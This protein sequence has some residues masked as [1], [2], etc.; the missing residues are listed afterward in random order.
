MTFTPDGRHLVTASSDGFRLWPA[1]P[2]RR[3]EAGLRHA[4]VATAVAL[5]PDGRLAAGDQAGFDYLATVNAAAVGRPD[6]VALL[7]SPLSQGEP[8]RHL[9]FSRDGRK[10]LSGGDKVV[11]QW[12]AATGEPD[13]PPLAHG[14]K[15][16]IDVVAFD[17]DGAGAWTS[18]EETGG[19]A[20]L[21]HWSLADGEARGTSVAF[22]GP[23]AAPR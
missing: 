23:G 6:C 7:E 17:R 14:A 20:M 1:A 5:G 4:S 8:V 22:E 12:S 21:R 13:G 19:R 2:P 16:H 3:P 9:L 10:L 18:A 11:R 15:A